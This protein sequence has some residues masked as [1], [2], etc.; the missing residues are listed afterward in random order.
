M[1][2]NFYSNGKLL[3]T[4]EYAVLDGALSLALPARFGQTLNVREIKG[5]L[6]HWK[7]RDADGS[8]WFET[9]MDVEELSLQ[10]SAPEGSSV[11]TVLWKMLGQAKMLNPGFLK[12]GVGY[13]VETRLNFPRNWGLGT[14][15]TLINNIA[16]WAGV[17]AYKLLM[18]S[19]PGSGYDIAC[20]QHNTPLLYRLK[21]DLPE[22]TPISFAP[23]F[24]EHLYFVHLNK[25]QSSRQG[26][27]DYHEKKIDRK[28]L[29]GQISKITEAVHICRDLPEFKNLLEEHEK[30]LSQ[31]LEKRTVK[32]SFFADF[33]GTI[34]SLGAWGGDFILAVGNTETPA[35]FASKG[36]HTILP[37]KKMVL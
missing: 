15:S 5:N 30:I 23:P 19:I 1:E 32:A 37:F 24:S 9:E 17:D 16:Q 13:Q 11:K 33:H 7:S 20:A 10:A 21:D 12:K 36:Y 28:A 14:S 6:L 25:K 34:K 3:L 29:V 26:I 8:I 27:S 35:Y 31:A 4:G 22:I 2:Y 18:N